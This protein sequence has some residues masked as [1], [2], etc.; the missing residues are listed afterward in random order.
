MF[1]LSKKEWMSSAVAGLL[2]GVLSAPATYNLVNSLTERAGLRIA[3]ADGCPNAK[4]LVLHSIVY[5]LIARVVMHY[6]EYDGMVVQVSNENKWVYSIAGGVLFAVLG[7][8]M[9]YRL[10]NRLTEMVGL[11][12]AKE[13]GCPNVYGLIVHSV[14]FALIVAIAMDYQVSIEDELLNIENEL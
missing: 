9:T 3:K 4:G 7:A 12:I 2:F 8:P 6:T 14:V 10:V 5:A 13:D 11:R 1:Q